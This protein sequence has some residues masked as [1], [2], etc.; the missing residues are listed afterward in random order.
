V[1]IV[2]N[3]GE[4]V[5]RLPVLAGWEPSLRAMVTN[6]EQRL[7]VEG[8]ITGLQ[9]RAVAVDTVARRELLM[10]RMRAHLRSARVPQAE[11]LF[12]QLK[13]LP[14][15]N[16]FRQELQT[17]ERSVLTNDPR[18]KRKIDKLLADT[19]QVLETHLAEQRVN[20]LANEL[21]GAKGSAGTASAAVPSGTG[22]T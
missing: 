11:A 8:F 5:A 2:K 6:D 4:P 15:L 14:G 22:G 17:F 10:A 1:L 12:Q 3:G 21:Q 13:A 7:R 9:E 19:R 16:E 18:L 20:D